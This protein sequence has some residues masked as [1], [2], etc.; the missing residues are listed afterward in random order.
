METSATKPLTLKDLQRHLYIAIIIAL[1]T[2]VVSGIGTG[3]G[4][5]YKTVDK[6]DEHT[7]VISKL[8]QNVDALT[9]IVNDL[10]TQTAV[11]S[12][13]PANLQKQIDDLK[14]SMEKIDD[15]TEKIYD[16]MLQ[17]RK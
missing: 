5:Y 15:K 3:V 4:V 7:V 17:G 14:R 10:K 11:V 1:G 8:T 16:L 13:S 9:G 6:V 12:T 2:G